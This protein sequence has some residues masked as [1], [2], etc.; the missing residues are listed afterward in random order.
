M[1]GM[2]T[3]ENLVESVS[4]S[5]AMEGLYLSETEKKNGMSILLGE[6]TADSI[7]EQ[8]KQK[9]IPQANERH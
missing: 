6:K 9:Y 1:K 4:A 2:M 5:F 8:I 7:I 3:I